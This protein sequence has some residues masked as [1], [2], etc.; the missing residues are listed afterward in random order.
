MMWPYESVSRE[1]LEKRKDYIETVLINLGAVPTGY[2]PSVEL[3]SHGDKSTEKVISSRMIYKHG[4]GFF[5]VSEVLFPTRPFIVL[6]YAETLEDALM[7]CME[8]V[9]PFPFDLSEDEIFAEIKNTL[10]TQ[11]GEADSS[12]ADD[13]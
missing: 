6:E 2:M 13:E 5:R 10:L 7:N 12:V 4:G 11:I 1:Q 8:D 9:D 3:T